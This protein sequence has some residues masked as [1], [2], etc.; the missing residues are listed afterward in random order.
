[1]EPVVEATKEKAARKKR[2]TSRRRSTQ[3]YEHYFVR[4]DHWEHYYGFG[5][6]DPRFHDTVYNHTETLSW[7]G[8]VIL[9]EGFKYPK[10]LVT[11]SAHEGM[12]AE[13]TKPNPTIGSMYARGQE[14]NAY[15]FIPAEHMGQL[16]GLA[17]SGR[18]KTISFVGEPLK[19]RQGLIRS[20]SLSTEIEKESIK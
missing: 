17:V 20:I 10:A 8:H 2:R 12:M 13:S 3:D 14:I 4:V 18:L 5:P 16:V 9:P 11:L 7:T 6:G 15:V 19:W 1:M